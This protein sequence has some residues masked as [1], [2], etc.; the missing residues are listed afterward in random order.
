VRKRILIV[1]D[2]LDQVR[3]LALLLRD[4]G[5]TVDYAINGYVAVDIAKRL[6]PDFVILD[7]GLPGMDGF[8][9][10]EQI[11]REPDAAATRAVVFTAY[12]RD[13]YRERA[14]QAGFEE[15][16]VKPQVPD[17]WSRLLGDPARAA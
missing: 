14:R 13:D 16:I 15:Y 3:S 8:E 9:V 10:L 2:N 11:R 7:I 12:D 6:K 5:H 17:G 4:L 1:E